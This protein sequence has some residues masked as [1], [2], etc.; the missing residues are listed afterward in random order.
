MHASILSRLMCVRC[1]LSVPSISHQ[2]RVAMLCCFTFMPLVCMCVF[3]YSPLVPNRCGVHAVK[4]SPFGERDSYC[5]CM[6]VVLPEAVCSHRKP[7]MTEDGALVVAWLLMLVYDASLLTHAHAERTTESHGLQLDRVM[8]V[9]NPRAHSSDLTSQQKFS[10]ATHIFQS[11]LH[12][13]HELANHRRETR[14][15]SQHAAAHSPPLRADVSAREDRESQDTADTGERPTR[16]IARH[17]S[18]CSGLCNKCCLCV[19]EEIEKVKKR[20]LDR[21]KEGA[22]QEEMLNKLQQAAD[23]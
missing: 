20:R 11:D 18:A 13:V 4:F 7:T 14:A 23:L 3:T 17:A 12:K 9:D 2:P 21:E 8:E 22:D 16:N 5:A 15:S 6:R 10:S 19:Q 1:Q